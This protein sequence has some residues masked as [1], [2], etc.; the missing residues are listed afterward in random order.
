MY[1]AVRHTSPDLNVCESVAWA[2]HSISA[3]AAIELAELHQKE[4]ESQPDL[5]VI[6]RRR[7]FPPTY[8]KHAHSCAWCEAAVSC[9]QANK[10]DEACFPSRCVHKDDE[11]GAYT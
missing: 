9:G 11:C 4:L 1:N 8:K 6:E 10:R 7:H 3:G 2:S 5:H